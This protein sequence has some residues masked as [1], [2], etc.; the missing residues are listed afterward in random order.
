MLDERTDRHFS[1]YKLK[2]A[3]GLT[4]EQAL[5][6]VKTKFDPTPYDLA[7]LTARTSTGGT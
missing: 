3:E 7:R 6:K 2:I 5:E 1:F 4:H